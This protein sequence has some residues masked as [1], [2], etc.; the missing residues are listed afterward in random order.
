MISTLFFGTDNKNGCLGLWVVKARSVQSLLFQQTNRI[1]QHVP[2]AECTNWC[3]L[4]LFYALGCSCQLFTRILK[5]LVSRRGRCLAICAMD[6]A[7]INNSQID[8]STRY[9]FIWIWIFRRRKWTHSRHSK[10]DIQQ[11]LE[12][13]QAYPQKD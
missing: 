12:I 4:S 11:I 7:S 10:L 6:I 13:V 5:E 8:Q 1:I 2:L 9:L 3:S